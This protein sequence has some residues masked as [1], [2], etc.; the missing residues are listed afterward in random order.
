MIDAASHA[1]L[2]GDW[3]CKQNAKQ[4][5]LAMSKIRLKLAWCHGFSGTMSR[6]Q[7]Y[8]RKFPFYFWCSVSHFVSSPGIET[9]FR[10][11]VRSVKFQPL[12][13][14]SLSILLSTRLQ[15]RPFFYGFE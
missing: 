12:F 4:L 3:C 9:A 5:V 11:T 6:L 10:F 14:Y 8:Q 1:A 15:K 2:L 13:G 7:R